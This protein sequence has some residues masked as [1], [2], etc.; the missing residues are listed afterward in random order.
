MNF[1]SE[2]CMV[3]DLTRMGNKCERLFSE[4]NAFRIRL[5]GIRFY[6]NIALQISDQDLLKIHL[7]DC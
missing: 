4:T 2:R 7:I 3:I 6:D 5:K 1:R